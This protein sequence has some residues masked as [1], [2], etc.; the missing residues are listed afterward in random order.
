MRRQS[1]VDFHQLR[2]DWFANGNFMARAIQRQLSSRKPLTTFRHFPRHWLPLFE[3]ARVPWIESTEPSTYV[4]LFSGR[5]ESDVVTDIRRARAAGQLRLLVEVAASS[6]TV[7]CET[8]Q[9]VDARKGVD[10]H[11]DSGAREVRLTTWH[12]YSRLDVLRFDSLIATFSQS[13]QGVLFIPCAK[14]RPYTN[15]QSYRRLMTRM[16][17]AGMDL[18]RFDKI[19]ITSIGPVPE[20]Q[21]DND[22]VQRYDTGVRD[23]YRLL[24]Q[25]R[26]MLKKTH[27][28][29]AWD[30]MSF[31]PYSEVLNILALEGAIPR[32]KRLSDLRRRNIPVYRTTSGVSR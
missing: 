30:F 14:A 21:W 13:K 28:D 3:W 22:F 25:L 8:L 6:E 7:L 4:P 24:V 10:A 32:P 1:R 9:R 26:R 19:V 31:V 2:P 18:D 29:E 20:A 16:R 15:S 17:A 23:I 27:Y 12:S 11:C 5:S